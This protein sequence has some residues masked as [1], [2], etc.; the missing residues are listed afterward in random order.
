MLYGGSAPSTQASIMPTSRSARSWA[1]HPSAGPGRREVNK[2]NR[3][4]CQELYGERSHHA[5]NASIDHREGGRARVRKVARNAAED[6]DR[7]IAR[8]PR[9]QGVD[10]GGI[11]DYFQS[12]GAHRTADVVAV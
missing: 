9:R 1:F 12:H 4:L 11:A 7:R 8:E 6:D 10:D 5:G 2:R 3:S